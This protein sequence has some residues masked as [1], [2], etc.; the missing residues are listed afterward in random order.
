MSTYIA[1][2]PT[3]FSYRIEGKHVEIGVIPGDLIELPDDDDDDAEWAMAPENVAEYLLRGFGFVPLDA[4]T[5]AEL[6][7]E[8]N[9]AIAAVKP[10]AVLSQLVREGVALRAV[11]GTL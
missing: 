6:T 9:A 8:R 7:I 5:F 11:R 2:Q 10:R 1:T 3:S 4:G